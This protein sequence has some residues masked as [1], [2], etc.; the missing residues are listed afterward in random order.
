[1]LARKLTSPLAPFIAEFYFVSFDDFLFLLTD[2]SLSD[3]IHQR[4]DLR[5]RG[6]LFV[7]YFFCRDQS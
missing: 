7:I 5:F 1:M 2:S 3:L 4:S 6:G